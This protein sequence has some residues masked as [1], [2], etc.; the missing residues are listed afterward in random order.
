M[1]LVFFY[2]GEFFPLGKKLKNNEM[3]HRFF[4]KV[5]PKL[6]RFGGKKL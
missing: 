6:A 3:P 4:W 1:W 2:F 5:L